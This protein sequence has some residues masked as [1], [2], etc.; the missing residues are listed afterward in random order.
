[1]KPIRDLR[2]YADHLVARADPNEGGRIAA[3]AAS[4]APA[5]APWL[6]RVAVVLGSLAIFA[7]ANAGLALAA[8]SSAP[9]DP[10]YGIDR[11]YEKIETAIGLHPNLAAERFQEAATLSRRGDLD[12]AFEV[13]SEAIQELSP[14]S[15]ALDVLSEVAEGI[16]AS[17]D[18][19]AE[20]RDQ[21]AS[22]ARELFGIGEEV[23]DAATGDLDG[24]ESRS[25][26][27]LAAIKEA[28]QKRDQELPPGLSGDAPGNSGH[29]PGQTDAPG[30]SGDAP[31]HGGDAPGNSGDAPGHGGDAPGKSGQSSGNS[32]NP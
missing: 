3:R 12:G 31:G 4:R 1:M 5:H 21:L 19:P 25:E 6:R 30:N 23:S 20:V 29:A 2:S 24:F 9:G 8:N 14:Q 26:R 7:G 22:Q 18:L 32:Q 10:L 13:A 17:S 11:A 27:V 15:H 28:M 16:Q